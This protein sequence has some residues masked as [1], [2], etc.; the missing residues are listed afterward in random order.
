MS[1]VS[2]RTFI[3][4]TAAGI[5]VVVGAGS[6]IPGL[7][8]LIAFAAGGGGEV[9]I[10]IGVDPTTFDS[11][12]SQVTEGDCIAH[13]VTEETLF[14]DDGGKPVPQLAASWSYP[15]PT[16][17]ALK[18]R[19]GIKF[20][21]GEPLDSAAIKYTIESILDPKNGA[22]AAERRGWFS[23]IVAIET[24]DPLSVNLKLSEP[25]H[26]VLSY[27]TLQGI[28]PPKAAAEMSD[29]FGFK[30][31]GTG[32]FIVDSYVPGDRIVLLPNPAF[33]DGPPKPGK[34]TIRF[35]PETATRMAALEAGEV[36]AISNVDPLALDRIKHSAELE[37]LS[38]PSVRIVFVAFMTDRPP[39][40]NLKLRQAV[41]HA[42][43]RKS[44][45]D[46]LLGGNGEVAR[47]VYAPGVAYFKPQEPYSFDPDLAK[48]LI[49]ESGFDTS[50]VL[51]F[52]H[53]S[54]RTVND[55]AVGEAIAGM[56]QNVGLQVEA[57]A[58]EW[59]TYL[60]N[61]QKRRIYDLV[62]ASMSPDNL[63]PDYAL[64]PW[65]RSD[66]S[67]IKYSN[68]KADDLIRRGEQAIQDGE[69]NAIYSELQTFL[70][71]DLGYAPLYV[72]PQLWARSKR[73]SGFNLRRDSIWTFEE[74]SLAK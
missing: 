42:I 65:F 3:T 25:N 28:L 14:R 20:T 38:V 66:T 12:R 8:D 52:A 62:M 5:G 57:D 21:N 70:W 73:L 35:I 22:T 7:G 61:Y 30:P 50:R 64:F 13:A 60:E 67:F 26:A 2:R 44:I 34:V 45:V 43:D 56:L 6:P 11:R 4:R 33:R 18:L 54:G 55:R 15:Q 31:I 9:I 37:T 51:K 63:D 32:P 41:M 71:N 29:N 23:P 68:P 10:G 69:L 74:A 17:L 53:P 58:P 1:E 72:V 39:F 36:H 19:Q 24:P 49:A 48:K 16:T 47:S 40:N 59:G 46:Q 27:L